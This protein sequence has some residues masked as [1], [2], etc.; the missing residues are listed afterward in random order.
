MCP[1]RQIALRMLWNTIAAV[2]SLYDIGPPVNE[3]GTP[4]VLKGEFKQT[5]IVRSVRVP[6]SLLD[7]YLHPTLALREPKPFKCSIKPRSDEAKRV[8]EALG[9]AV[10]F[11]AD[12]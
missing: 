8:I 12:N 2:L 11:D 1:G 5:G 10:S 7:T 6:F 4:N 9:Q 3:D